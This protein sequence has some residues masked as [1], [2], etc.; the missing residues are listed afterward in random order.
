MAIAPQLGM[1]LYAL[2][3]SPCWGFVWLCMLFP[4][5]VCNRPTMSRRHCLLRLP[6]ASN[7]KSLC[8]V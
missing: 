1:G 2:L 7:M 5:A 4:N 8:T 6:I 3:P